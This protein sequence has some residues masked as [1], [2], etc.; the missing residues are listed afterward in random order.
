[1]APTEIIRMPKLSHQTLSML[2][3]LRMAVGWWHEAPEMRRPGMPRSTNLVISW[4]AVLDNLFGSDMTAVIAE[5]LRSPW[6]AP[7][8]AVLT[9][10]FEETALRLVT[11]VPAE[12]LRTVLKAP[13]PFALADA[14]SIQ[15]A[16]YS[17]ALQIHD[18]QQEVKAP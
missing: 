9:E 15:L 18:Q 14:G 8:S 12:A 6:Q 13:V 11:A 10:A 4:N 3:H 17:R 2:D 5:R 7:F 16:L 1:M